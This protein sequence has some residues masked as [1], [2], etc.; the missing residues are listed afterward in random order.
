MFMYKK[1]YFLHWSGYSPTY[2]GKFDQL[3]FD[4]DF[5]T[6]CSKLSN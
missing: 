5:F 1:Q 3:I 6:F 4:F 2:V